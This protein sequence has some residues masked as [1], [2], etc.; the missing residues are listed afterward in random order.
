MMGVVLFVTTL[1]ALLLTVVGFLGLTGKLPRNAWVGIRTPYSMRSD[2]HWLATHREGAAYLIFAG[3]AA[4][5]AGAAFVPFAL[6]GK[7]EDPLAAVVVL[8]QAVLV[9][10]GAL[11]SWLVGTSRARRQL[12]A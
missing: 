7:I 6:A 4:F 10:V 3:V 1:A 11:M 9:L 5:A 2:E 12:G 8:G